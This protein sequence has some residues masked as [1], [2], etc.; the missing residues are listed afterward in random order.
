MT[1]L[2]RAG[3]AVAAIGVAMSGIG[4]SS[5]APAVTRPVATASVATRAGTTAVSKTETVVREDIAAD[6]STTS[7]DRRTIGL[8]VSDTTNLRGR[9]ELDVS[10]TGAHPTGGLVSDVN[11]AAGVNE[12][13]PFVLL[14]CRGVDST[15]V[16]A[17]QRISPETCWTQTSVERFNSN[18]NTQYPAWRSDAH[19]TDAHRQRVVDAPSPRPS[20]CTRAASAERWIPMVGVDGTVYPGGPLGCGGQAPEAS[21]IGGTGLPSN[22]TYGI[23]GTDGKGSAQFSA[24]TEDENATLGCS[25]S[26]KCSLVAI[27]VNGISCDG[28]GTKLPAADQ[29]DPDTGADA[30]STCEAPDVYRAGQFAI[31]GTQPNLATSGALWWS[32]SNW[33]NRITVPLSFAVS[34]NVCSVVSKDKPLEI[35]GSTLMSQATAQWQPKFCT[36]KSLYPFVHV[37]T[38][39]SSARTLLQVGNINAA[40]SSRSPDGGFTRPTVQAPVAVT[41]FAISFVVDGSDGQ[42]VANLKLDPRLLAKLLSESYPANAIGKGADP[43]LADNPVNITED[44]EFQA[45]NPGLPQYT[46]KESAAALLTLSSDA[47]M[48]YALTSYINDDADARAFLDGK[49][50]P[51]GMVVNP[52]YKNV[53]LPTYSWPLQ[54]TNNADAAYID[55][56]NN[57][58]YSHSPSAY[59][60]LISNPTAVIS[61][62]VLNM[63]YGISNV[64]TECPNGDP[65]DVSTLKLQIQGRQQPGSRFLLGVVPLSSVARYSLSAASLQAGRADSTVGDQK[66]DAASAV[67]A[68][69]YV[70][71][72]NAG[73]KAAAALFTADKAAK[74]WTVDYDKLATDAGKTA[75]PGTLPVYTQIPTKGLDKADAKNLAGFLSYVIGT[76]Q[77]PGLE[78]G[79]LPPGYL[80]LTKANGLAAEAGYTTRA[81]AAVEQQKGFVP[82]LDAADDASAPNNPSGTSPTGPGIT[83]PSLPGTGSDPGRTQTGPKAEVTPETTTAF[84]TVG[85]HSALSR[86]AL[87][88]VL[89]L[90]LLLGSVG[91]VMRWFPVLIKVATD[92]TGSLRS[93]RGRS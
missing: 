26:V 68:R 44:P 25:S 75:Y 27:P 30:Q 81:I 76:G 22:A 61:T 15:S 19:E 78:N 14:E 16:P 49:A 74:T 51:W 36:D 82:S 73:L 4:F 77:V 89:L 1:R 20:G 11:S 60:P 62:I 40:F 9:Q 50:D 83:S 39:D 88:M 38:S 32:A 43:A 52:A 70:A 13:Y 46:A 64:N 66:A 31:S 91:V 3:Y 37:Q 58:C 29:P 59:L 47:D 6:G 42:P 23:T 10:W 24:W 48:V 53:S 56:G 71:S 34:A 87:P 67:K 86:F 72:N 54:D 18:L 5:P 57:P 45:L 12:E 55:G 84:R 41:G 17:S 80:P 93:W 63:Q 8:K 21:N 2:R 85:A 7:V 79:Q 33:R 90:C 28:Y 92:G 65:T 35:Y 69:S